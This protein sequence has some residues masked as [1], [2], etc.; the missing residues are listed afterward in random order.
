ML[1]A[2]RR[3]TDKADSLHIEIA[4]PKSVEISAKMAMDKIRKIS[5]K[6]VVGNLRDNFVFT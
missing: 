4:F 5:K 2:S 3:S 1:F 6:V